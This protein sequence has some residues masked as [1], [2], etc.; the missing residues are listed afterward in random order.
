M[1]DEDQD[2]AGDGGLGLA[3]AAGD[4][5][6]VLAEEGGVQA[7]L[8]SVSWASHRIQLARPG[9]AGQVLILGHAGSCTASRTPQ[10]EEPNPAVFAGRLQ[11]DDLRAV[12][13]QSVGQ[14]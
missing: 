13:A 3:A 10:H 6:V 4:P 1:P 7:A 2:G 11:R 9:S 8:F 12:L 14:R 5:A